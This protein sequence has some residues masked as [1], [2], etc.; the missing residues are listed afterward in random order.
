M[1]FIKIVPFFQCILMSLSVSDSIKCEEQMLTSEELQIPPSFN[2]HLV[3]NKSLILLLL[4][5]CQ[6]R[7]NRSTSDI[8]NVGYIDNLRNVL[9]TCGR[10]LLVH[11]AHICAYTYHL[12]SSQYLSLVL[13]S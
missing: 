2:M 12:Y 10:F 11:N 6:Y 3:I 7:R 8:G 13:K 1:V 4:L 5:S 9:R